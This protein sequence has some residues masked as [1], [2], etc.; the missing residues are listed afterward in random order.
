MAEWPV[1]VNWAL[2][3]AFWLFSVALQHAASALADRRLLSSVPWN[4]LCRGRPRFLV[5]FCFSFWLFSVSSPW[6]C[7]PHHSLLSIT[8]PSAQFLWAPWRISFISPL[9]LPGPGIIFIC[10]FSYSFS[11]CYPSLSLYALFYFPFTLSISSR[12]P[13]SPMHSFLP[14]CRLS[15]HV[16]TLW[17]ATFPLSYK[18]QPGSFVAD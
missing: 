16:Q 18:R 12:T 1:F 6:V 11:L 3:S 13:T 10:T 4:C 2:T 9:I 17:D 7:S 5:L 8:R 15:Q 14:S